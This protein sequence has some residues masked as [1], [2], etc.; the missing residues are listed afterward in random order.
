ML[1]QLIL[2]T[3]TRRK[4]KGIYTVTLDT[5][6]AQ[7]REPQLL[8]EEN[9]PTYLTVNRAKTLFSVTSIEEKGGIAAYQKNDAQF[10]RTDVAVEEGA[11]PCYVAFDEARQLV[12]DANYHRGCVHVYRAT[13]EGT[14]QLTDTVTHTEPT[15]PH[16]NQQV[17]HVHYADLTPDGR[18]AVCDLGTD[19]VYTYDISEE[20][21]LS[22]V[23]Q[24]Q[25]E[26]GTGP[27]HLVFHP[28]QPI[29]YLFGELDSTITVLAYQSSDGT[30]TKIQK[31][32]TLPEDFDAFNA[33]AAIRVSKDGRFL[34]ASN[35][36]HNSIAV[37]AIAENGTMLERIQLIATEGEIPRDF[38]LN[39]SEQFLIAANQ[40]TDNL[41]LFKRNPQT[42]QLTCL[43]KDVSVP[44]CVCVYATQ[45]S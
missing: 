14:L 12:F 9:N 13:G 25:S 32:S 26:P 1:E 38:A 24:Y 33:G 36:G 19:R 41:T 22:N 8:I 44:E 40:D 30:F 2:G 16:P 39:A 45:E 23:A 43:Q 4:S 34:Y 37:F 3:Y 35:R 42:G 31:I 15:G 17:P 29:A 5:E 27:R 21:T 18:L 20:G 10:Q 28:T 6:K 7:L 11:A